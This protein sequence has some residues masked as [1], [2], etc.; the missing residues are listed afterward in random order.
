MYVKIC[1]GSHDS[2]AEHKTRS[3]KLFWDNSLIIILAIYPLVETVS[4]MLRP[5]LGN[6]WV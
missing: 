2:Q 5:T 4:P 3:D 6:S 1:R